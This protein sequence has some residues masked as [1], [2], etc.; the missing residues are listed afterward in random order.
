MPEE[1][2]DPTP[3][4]SGFLV[5]AGEVEGPLEL[6]LDLIEQ[7]R[8]LVNEVS[9][10]QVTDDYIAF[11]RAN[12]PFP[13]EDATQFLSVA[14][15]LLLIKS[16]SLLPEL[17]LSHEEEQ[18]VDALTR[19]LALYE[20]ARDAARALGAVFGTRV[21]AARGDREPEV[22]FSPSADLTLPNLERSL[23]DLL[24]R[25]THAEQLP[26]V[27]VRP[28]VSIEEMMDSLR[29]RVE[30]ALTLSFKDFTGDRTEK[31]EVIVSFLAL[32]ELVKQGTVNA[33]QHAHFA[34]I[35]IEHT[36]MAVP[37]YG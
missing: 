24:A 20:K 22:R 23:K 19:R 30:R 5:R 29:T 10:A 35:R 26:E 27:R 36:G 3:A 11:V 7:R 37:R 31:V 14:A 4:A 17:E 16:R 21:L 1:A 2:L 33:D 9:L 12:E 34:D 28:L 32:L 8:L 6:I 18:D 25:L 13:L 15:T